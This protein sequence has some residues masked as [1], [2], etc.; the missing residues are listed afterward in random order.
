MSQTQ[1]NA[2][3]GHT[4]VFLPTDPLRIQINLTGLEL[5]SR[6][7]WIDQNLWLEKVNHNLCSKSN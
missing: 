6:L 2:K 5:T 3:R 7:E 4:R 1:N